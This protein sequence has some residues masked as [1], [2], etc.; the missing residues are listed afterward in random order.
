MQ[1]GW[2]CNKCHNVYAPN[3]PFCLYCWF[4]TKD[5]SIP[6]P[7]PIIEK[8]IEIIETVQEV[9]EPP[10]ILP[11]TSESSDLRV[12]KELIIPHVDIELPV[13]NK[14][15][16]VPLSD[17]FPDT[18]IFISGIGHAKDRAIHR[19]FKIPYILDSILDF[20]LQPSKLVRQ[21]FDFINSSDS[22]YL[23]DSGA[24]TYLMNP[25]KTINLED[26]IKRYCYYINEFD[27]KHFF[28]L[29]IDVFLTLDE[30]ENIRRKIYLETHKSPIIVYHDERGHDYW[31]KM[32]KENDFIAIG[33]IASKK[34]YTPSDYQRYSDLCDEAHA[35]GTKVHGLGFT[36]LS[37]INTRTMFFDTVDSTSWNYSKRGYAAKINE[38]GEMTKVELPFT[39]M[40][41]D[42]Q[43]NDLR[44]WAKFSEDYRGGL[45]S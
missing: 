27:I 32:C 44:T 30:I 43:E 36:P 34:A 24:F 8:P 11:T 29:D 20:P 37:L 7:E 39:Y 41:I 1:E 42:A 40:T 23:L 38:K 15:P 13:L 9:N 26:Y 6:V 22:E 21:Y 3:I 35:Y 17:H 5:N 12:N 33:G 10:I 31:L 19:E 4:Q 14:T 45:R 16:T 18:K 28:E 25:K 2:E